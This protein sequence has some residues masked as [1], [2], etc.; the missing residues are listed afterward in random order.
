MIVIKEYAPLDLK[1]TLKESIY[2]LHQGFINLSR[3]KILKHLENKDLIYTFSND[4]TNELA[5]TI[6]VKWV[7]YKNTVT[8]H[9]GS[10]VI[11]EKYQ[12]NNFLSHTICKVIVKT[13]LKYPTKKAFFSCFLSNPKAYNYTS[14]PLMRHPSPNTQTP[15]EIIDVMHNT[16]LNIA[17]SNNFT[18]DKDIFII[19][20]LNH[21]NLKQ[22]GIKYLESKD[23]F[24]EKVNPDYESGKQLMMIFP[25]HPTG[26][27]L[28]LAYGTYFSLK[29]FYRGAQ[30]SVAR[31]YQHCLHKIKRE[32]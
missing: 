29:N 8:A 27:L 30:E 2:Q 9:L 16:V 1:E 32:N 11:S 20:Y 15:Q 12:R 18:A 13:H 21:K 3:K 14:R 31:F 7:H 28:Y 22:K 24:F 26:I 23:G 10:I 25:S 6:S 5:A 4:E 17:G 19:D